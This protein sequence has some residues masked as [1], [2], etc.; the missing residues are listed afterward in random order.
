LIIFSFYRVKFH[1]LKFGTDPA[2]DGSK[3]EA[4]PDPAELQ[5]ALNAD[6]PITTQ[7]SWRQGR[8]L[9]RQYLQEIGYTDTI[10]DVRSNRVRSL[11]GLEGGE[12]TS[13]QQE[14][15]S[16]GSAEKRPTS[17]EQ[18]RSG[19][20]PAKKVKKS[21]NKLENSKKKLTFI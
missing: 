12:Q 1:K 14:N 20:P 19:Q 10:I 2:P 7:V 11:L 9:L 18:R 4:E 16:G 21:K 3:P 15:G 8:Q 5:A 6:E 13:A 17:Q